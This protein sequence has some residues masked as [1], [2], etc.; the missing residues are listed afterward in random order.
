MIGEWN[1][2]Y[3]LTGANLIR[4]IF[5]Y[6][7]FS[8]LQQGRLVCKSWH[9]FLTNDRILWLKMVMKTKPY[10]ENVFI[11]L[12]YQETN[13]SAYFVKKFFEY[14]KKQH[15]LNYKQLFNL[16]GRIV[17]MSFV[18]ANQANLE[19]HFI[20]EKLSQEI[21]TKRQND[22]ICKWMEKNY[23]NVRIQKKDIRDLKERINALGNHLPFEMKL[24]M[25]LVFL[26]RIF[27]I[28]KNWVQLMFEIRQHL[29]R[30]LHMQLE[31]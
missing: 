13:L 2:N 17:S 27:K 31:I 28:E 22:F 6:L 12:T 16:F 8:S 26:P 25:Q 21:E 24:E 29:M 7:D 20:G 14:I 15:S 5:S 9:Q 23:K 18:I 10:L 30:V 4:W 11:K 3:G 1:S 19:Y